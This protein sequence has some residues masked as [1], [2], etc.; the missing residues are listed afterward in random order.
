LGLE[1]NGPSRGHFGVTPSVFATLDDHDAVT[2]T[3]AAE[4]ATLAELGAMLTEFATLA[5]FAAALAGLGTRA[6][7]VSVLADADTI[8]ADDNVLSAG[9]RRGRNGEHA[10]GC[11]KVSKFLHAVLLG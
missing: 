3:M 11:N 8:P 7:A 2:V 9:N 6:G 5:E 4:F 10:K 1:K